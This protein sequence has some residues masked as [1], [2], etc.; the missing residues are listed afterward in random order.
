[1]GFIDTN[2]NQIMLVHSRDDISSCINDLLFENSILTICVNDKKFIMVDARRSYSKAINNSLHLI[3]NDIVPEDSDINN[4][5][6]D[7]KIEFI[8][9]SVLEKYGIDTT[10][11][12]YR[13][14]V[15]IISDRIIRVKE[16]PSSFKI[17]VADLS[18]EVGMSFS[19]VSRNIRYSIRN[20]L[21]ECGTMRTMVVINMLIEEV[22]FL[23]EN[24]ISE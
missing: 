3:D 11:V 13:L 5:S 19:Q 12:G 7:L 23:L 17:L 4:H 18:K 24:A 16:T 8:I 15:K 1:M 2:K 20:S 14:L 10:L 9:S 22:E 21:I 6:E